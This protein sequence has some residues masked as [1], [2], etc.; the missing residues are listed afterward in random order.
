MS[1]ES[2]IWVIEEKQLRAPM[3]APDKWK[4]ADS[5][6][7]LSKS[8]VNSGLRLWRQRNRSFEYRAA[9]YVRET[10]RKG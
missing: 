3:E 1:A 5:L 6:Y 9:A 4:R 2:R 7:Y 10:E 8:Q